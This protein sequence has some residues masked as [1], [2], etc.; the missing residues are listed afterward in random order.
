MY[1]V[2]LQAVKKVLTKD[3]YIKYSISLIDEVSC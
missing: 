1:D 3:I 2:A